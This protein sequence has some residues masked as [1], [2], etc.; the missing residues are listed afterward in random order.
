MK[1]EKCKFLDDCYG[2]EAHDMEER[3]AEDMAE[4]GGY[5]SVDAFWDSMI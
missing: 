5:P 4:F 1:C 3:F 2:K